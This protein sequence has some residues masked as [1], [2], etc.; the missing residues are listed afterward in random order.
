MEL[1]IS[2]KALILCFNNT[3]GIYLLHLALFLLNN[4]IQQSLEAVLQENK[5]C[6]RQC[7][8]PH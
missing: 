4:L 1:D 7:A 2:Q 5:I 6:S 3:K 8:E